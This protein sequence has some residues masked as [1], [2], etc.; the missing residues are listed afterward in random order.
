ME[1]YLVDNLNTKM[2]VLIQ[3]LSIKFLFNMMLVQPIKTYRFS[4]AI[5]QLNLKNKVTRFFAQD[6]T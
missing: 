4:E 5:Y 1:E 3:F 6:C 2:L